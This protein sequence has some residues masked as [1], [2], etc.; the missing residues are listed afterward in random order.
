[1]SSSPASGA[2]G[3]ALQTVAGFYH[4][5]DAWSQPGS[6]GRSASPGG[7]CQ[8]RVKLTSAAEVDRELVAWIRQA[9]DAA[10]G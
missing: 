7:M 8:Y 5:V 2:G 6:G 9:Y 3:F 10:G 4:L 1:M